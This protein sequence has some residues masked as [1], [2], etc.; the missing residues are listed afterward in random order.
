M[1]SALEMVK[2]QLRHGNDLLSMDS[3]R[4]CDV[5][6]QEQGR[7]LRQEEF[8]IHQGRKKSLRHV[9]L[10]DDLVLFSKTKRSS[11]GHDVYIYKGSIKVSGKLCKIMLCL[12]TGK[13]SIHMADHCCLLVPIH[14]T[15]LK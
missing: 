9:F 1:Q 13:D 15:Q 4:G 2:F 5:N 12:A 14:K 3:L 11:T 7:L 10:F 6:L 8:L